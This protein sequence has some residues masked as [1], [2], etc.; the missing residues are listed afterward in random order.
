MDYLSSAMNIVESQIENPI[1]YIFSDDIP[2]CMKNLPS[3]MKR[4][5]RFPENPPGIDSVLTDMFLMSN[6][7][8]NIRGPST[9]SW[10]AA[11]LNSNPDKIVAAPH[12]KLW[13]RDTSG[14]FDLLPNKW[15]TVT[16]L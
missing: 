13:F 12:P 9:F 8:H 11:W 1:F 14:R 7:R 10:W 16:R 2:W 3:L 5:L 6:C 4:P 15:I